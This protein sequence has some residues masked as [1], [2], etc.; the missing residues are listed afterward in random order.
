MEINSNNKNTSKCSNLYYNLLIPFLK[1]ILTV[2]IA[3]G[4]H[5]L[6][7]E[8]YTT[9]CIS[10]GWFSLFHSLVYVPTPQCR[11][12]LDIIKY[13]SDLYVLFWTTLFS[14]IFLN[15]KSIRQNVGI[16]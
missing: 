12:L 3:I 10:T 8:I 15:F 14:F 11:V 1:T 7:I 6:T 16:F 2:F 5:I 9:Y 4:I 13:T